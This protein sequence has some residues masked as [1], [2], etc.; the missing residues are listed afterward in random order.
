MNRRIRSLTTV[1][2]AFA[3][4]LAVA[5]A[6]AAPLLK[7]PAASRQTRTA[8]VASGTGATTAARPAIAN[9]A[10]QEVAIVAT[11]FSPGNAEKVVLATIAGA[12]RE[13]RMAAYTFSSRT[14]MRELA[15][16][17]ARGVDIRLVLD[18]KGANRTTIRNLQA[19]RIPFRTCVSYK[20]MHNKFLVID[21]LDVQTG[22]Y[23]Y[24]RAAALDNA[25]NV[26]VLRGSTLAA[27][28]LREWNRLWEESRQP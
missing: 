16:A 27:S 13:I 5:V 15:R 19:A 2:L 28:Y 24:T 12:R 26:I 17:R 7:A 21:G 20:I 4:V 22:S 1:A 10:G 14:V 3:A 18:S 8:A 6:A 9:L 23:N 25:E 11:G